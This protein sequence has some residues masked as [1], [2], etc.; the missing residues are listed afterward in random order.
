LGFIVIATWH[1]V[2]LSLN[3]IDLYED[4]SACGWRMTTEMI[5]PSHGHNAKY[6]SIQ[7][8]ISSAVMGH[9]A[10]Q[11][12]TYASPTLLGLVLKPHPLNSYPS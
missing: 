7:V 5:D 9:Q 1:T 2:T 10:Y 6:M 11:P 12:S 4:L 8:N 3:R